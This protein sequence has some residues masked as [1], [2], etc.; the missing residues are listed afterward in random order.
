MGDTDEKTH[1]I[2]IHIAQ[3]VCRELR[4][5]RVDEGVLVVARKTESLQ[6]T[7]LAWISPKTGGQTW[8]VLINRLPRQAL[9]SS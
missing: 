9:E 3:L 4:P 6:D 5:V 1:H 7:T 8:S 2:G